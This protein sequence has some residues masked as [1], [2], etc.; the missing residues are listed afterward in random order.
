M[1]LI[2]FFPTST[3]NKPVNIFDNLFNDF[4]RDDYP[5]SFNNGFI[6]KSPAVNIAETADNYRIEVAA[7]GLEKSDFEVKV[8]QDVLT[9]SAKKE[10]KAAE[11]GGKFTRREFNY[12]EFKR[13]FH[14]PETVNVEHIAANYVNGILHVTLAKREE[15]KPAPAKT[16]EIK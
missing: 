14:L 7:P 13:N 5:V 2:K 3:S 11:N 6:Q 15:D 1:S 16:I 10:A 9:I 4:F 8:D 12:F